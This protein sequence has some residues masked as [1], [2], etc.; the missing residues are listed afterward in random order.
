MRL[1]VFANNPP[2]V[3]V[4]KC[5][6]SNRNSRTESNIMTND[7]AKK[8]ISEINEQITKN[9]VETKSLIFRIECFL[10]EC[11]I[12]S[13]NVNNPKP[14][15]PLSPERRARINKGVERDKKLDMEWKDKTRMSN[16][17]NVEWRELSKSEVNCWLAGS[18]SSYRKEGNSNTEERRLIIKLV[19]DSGVPVHHIDDIQPEISRRGMDVHNIITRIKAYYAQ[20][21]RPRIKPV[22]VISDGEFNKDRV[23]LFR[24]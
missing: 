7:E 3:V 1:W 10:K 15:D 8:A 2:D 24:A 12:L 6:G 11:D 4:N 18:D 13:E 21:Y 20:E 23:K 16:Q 22:W 14:V 19:R 9:F 5:D 17:C